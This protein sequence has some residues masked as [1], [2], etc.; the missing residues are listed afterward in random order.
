MAYQLSQLVADVRKRAKDTSF[1][2]DL[3][4]DYIQAT[5]NE[6]LQRS[7]FPFMEDA[8]TAVL[9]ISTTD[10]ALAADV[11]VILSL[12]LL[13]TDTTPDTVFAPE[14]L[15]YPTFFERFDPETATAGT[16]SYYTVYGNTVM[17]DVPLTK[18]YTLKVKYLKTPSILSIDSDVPDVPER[19]KE[20]LIRGALS[21]VE[22]YRDNFDIA[23]IHQRKVE[24]LTEDMLG[25]L[26]QRQ[27][28]TPHRAR[29]G[30][31]RVDRGWGD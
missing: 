17:W 6:V 21:R 2:S 25:R 1:D 15:A 8:T 19:F 29:F 4:T 13:D 20:I 18:A 27:L 23:A 16:P 9:T 5:Q 30:R 11:D 26:S 31:P 3:I 22:D 28:V 12:K 14:Y 10:Y 7:R 24:E